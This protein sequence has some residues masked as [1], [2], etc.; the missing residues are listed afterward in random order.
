MFWL[1][2][3]CLWDSCTHSPL[4][5][6]SNWLTAV[7]QADLSLD[8]SS[9]RKP[10]K[11]LSFNPMLLNWVQFCHSPKGYLIMP[12]DRCVCQNMRE[13]ATST[14]W[15]NARD[16]IKHLTMHKAI[17]PIKGG[18]SHIAVILLFKQPSITHQ[19]PVYYIFR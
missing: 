16:P 7:H 13:S 12:G 11:A 2:G 18:L 15:I 8:I 3:Y 10:E 5:L 6:F 4:F 19:A 17:F 9:L 1:L 14:Q